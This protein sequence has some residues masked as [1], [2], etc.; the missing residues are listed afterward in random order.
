MV[1]PIPLH[2]R[3]PVIDA[4]TLEEWAE[5]DT[6]DLRFAQYHEMQAETYRF[7]IESRQLMRWLFGP[8][9]VAR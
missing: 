5:Q 9:G 4:A 3:E 2:P 8:E 1:E 6:E 7:C